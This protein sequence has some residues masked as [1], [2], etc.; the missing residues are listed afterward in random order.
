MAGEKFFEKTG[1]NGNIGF[2]NFPQ[3]AGYFAKEID[4]PVQYV[5][6]QGIK[7]EYSGKEESP[8]GDPGCRGWLASISASHLANPAIGV[9]FGA[10]TCQRIWFSRWKRL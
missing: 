5:D 7:G 1:F 6:N 8:A 3:S 9:T 4:D 2:S 10:F